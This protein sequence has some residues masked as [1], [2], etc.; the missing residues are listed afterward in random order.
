M[1]KI[2]PLKQEEMV[3][4]AIYVPKEVKDFLEKEHKTFG[5]KSASDFG[6]Q[7]LQQGIE[8]ILTEN[9]NVSNSRIPRKNR[10]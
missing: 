1:F 2:N 10:D 4:I 5:R 8:T 9:E 6:S 7:I 3:T